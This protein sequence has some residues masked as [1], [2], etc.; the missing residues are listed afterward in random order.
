MTRFGGGPLSGAAQ[1]LRSLIVF[2]GNGIGIARCLRSGFRHCFAVVLVDGYW[3]AL[4]GKDGLP[5][6]RVVAGESFDLAGFYRDHG[7]T[8]IERTAPC[9]PPRWPFVARTCVG[10]VKA[11]IGIRSW[12]VTPRQ[13]YL[14]LINRR[15]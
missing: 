14:N 11:M 2:H 9:P 13:L 10:A 1:A 4:D 3:I 5:E 15:N 8:V 6:L 12:A 7:F